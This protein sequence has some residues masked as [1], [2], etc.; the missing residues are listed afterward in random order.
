MAYRVKV[1]IS[2]DALAYLVRLLIETG[3]IVA[4]PRSDLLV[5]IAK[6][7]QTPGIGNAY[8]SANSLG[9][10]YRQV[11]QSTAKNVNAALG[12][13]QRIVGKEFGV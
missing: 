5:F 12:R 13:M 7:F 6:H 10:K 3:V 1:S 11:V 8:L 9:T 4:S 2:A